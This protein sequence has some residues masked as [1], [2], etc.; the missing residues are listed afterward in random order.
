[1]YKILIVED[2]VVIAKSIKNCLCQWNY[3]TEYIVNSN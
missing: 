1:M 3:E 2:G